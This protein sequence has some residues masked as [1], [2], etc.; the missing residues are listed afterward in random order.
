MLGPWALDP[1][2]VRRAPRLGIRQVLPLAPRED[3]KFFNFKYKQTRDVEIENNDERNFEDLRG[4]RRSAKRIKAVYLFE[5][6]DVVIPPQKLHSIGLRQRTLSASTRASF[7][8]HSFTSDRFS[9]P[10]S[11]PLF[12]DS[13]GATP[14]T[15]IPR[16]DSG[17]R[18]H[19]H[20]LSPHLR[21]AFPGGTR[22]PAVLWTLP[23]RPHPPLCV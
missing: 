3:C 8:T 7:R 6:F 5:G 17:Y 23:V 21:R 20:L 22:N 12:A 16:Y 13:P 2:P 14:Y 11:T 1:R 15:K 18:V 9:L 19:L 4:M 10:N